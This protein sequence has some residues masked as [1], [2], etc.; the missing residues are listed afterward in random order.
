MALRNIVKEPEDILRKTCKPVEVFDNKLSALI[1]D[2]MQTMNK[3]EGVGLAAPQV[4]VL[5]RVIYIDVGD[6]GLE[7]VNPEIVK[8]SGT[9]REVEGCLS[10]PDKWG[11]V[12]RPMN[13]VVKAKNRHGEDI[14]RK[15]S[16]YLARCICHEVDH[17]D[18]RLFVDIVDE[19]VD[20]KDVD[21]SKRKRRKPVR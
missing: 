1:D 10:C 18:G 20:P 5:R 14:V 12:K 6:G 8:R 16:D 2:L 19:F 9:Q 7:L 15:C 3:A 4:G 13:I 21:E 11:Y 17:L